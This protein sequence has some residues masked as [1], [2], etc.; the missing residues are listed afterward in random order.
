VAGVR[1]RAASPQR[2]VSVEVDGL[3]RVQDI[4]FSHGALALSP[5]ELRRVVI[6]A[7]RAACAEAERRVLAVA[8]PMFGSAAERDEF[9]R[10]YTP[11][12]PAGGSPTPRS[13]IVH[14][15]GSR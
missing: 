8:E 1:G 15:P 12:P 6:E 7:I 10:A 11:R 3:G 4:S 9:R 13:G 14:P 2:E 5:D